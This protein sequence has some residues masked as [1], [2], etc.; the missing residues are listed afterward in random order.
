M[1]QY[2]TLF[3]N[4]LTKITELVCPYCNKGR[5]EF[6]TEL[7]KEVQSKE[8]KQACMH[9]GVYFNIHDYVASIGG[10]LQC[11]HYDCRNFVSFVGKVLG[12]EDYDEDRYGEQRNRSTSTIKFDYLQPPIHIISLNDKYD[13]EINRLLKE[14]FSLY[15]NHYSA[16]ASTIRILLEKLC[17]IEGVVNNITLH[18]RLKKLNVDI[19][20]INILSAIKWIGNDGSH[21]IDKIKR[22]D[23]DS[24]YKMIDFVLD[25]LYIKSREELNK[26]ANEINENKGTVK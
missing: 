18:N 15:W 2:I 8:Q 7:C 21:C 16:C 26:L 5:L 9:E 22:A 13:D 14:S 25:E 23:L 19:T 20:I 12:G 24:A 6:R 10:V 11:N 17:D 4:E 1:D 3:S